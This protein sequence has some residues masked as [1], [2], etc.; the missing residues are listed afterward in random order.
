MIGDRLRAEMFFGQDPYRD[1]TETDPW[2]PHTHLTAEVVEWAFAETDC[3]FWV[4]AGTMLG[5]SALLVAETAKRLARRVDV[6]CIDPFTGDVN[7]WDWERD[8]AMNNRWRF[9]RLVNGAPTIRQRFLA[10]VVA[11]GFTDVIVPMQATSIVGLRYL[12]RLVQRDVVPRPDVV[13]VDS[14]HEEGETLIELRTAW[15]VVRAGGLLLGDDLDWVAV[16][17]D[18]ERFSSEVNGEVLT[19]GNQWAIRRRD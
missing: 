15:A 3:K 12:D 2:Y 8:L 6:L 18:V 17:R 14:A 19:F 9:L 4:E 1:A 13:Y 16:R 10:N 5:G 7:M 11:A